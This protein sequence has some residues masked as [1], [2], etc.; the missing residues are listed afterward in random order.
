MTPSGKI[1]CSLQLAEEGPISEDFVYDLL[2]GGRIPG[3]IIPDRVLK[4]VRIREFGKTVGWRIVRIATHPDVMGRG[5]GS[6]A[7][8]Q[9]IAEAIERGYDW[10]GAGFGVTEKLLRFWLKNGFIPVHMSPDRNPVSGEFTVLV[11][12]PLNTTVRRIISIANRE[13]KIKLLNSLHDTYRGLE[14]DVAL[15]ILKS[16]ETIDADY[17][18]KLDAIRWDRLRIYAYGPMTFEAACDVMFE[19]AKAYF[20]SYP[21]FK[22]KLSSIEQYILV[23]RVLQAKSWDEVA[24]DIGKRSSFVM[25]R[26]KEIAG[27]VAKIYSGTVEPSGVS[28]KNVNVKP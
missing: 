14:T 2:K 7:L 28:L 26:L 8:K 12:Y 10:V 20:I 25:N 5:I 16:G 9:V 6:F 18:P 3:N 19:I 21:Y 11:I 1:V 24:N 23:S 17:I 4:H 15:M 13:F 22:V 27:R